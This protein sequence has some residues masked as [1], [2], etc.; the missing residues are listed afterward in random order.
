MS[1]PVQPPLTVETIDGA[2]VGR[3]ITKIKVSN[4]TLT[5]SGS[6]ATITTGGGGGGSGTVTS[7]GL[8]ETGTALTITGSPV[9]T[10]GTI[11][12]AG[13]GTSSQVILGDLS[14]GTLTSGTVTGTGTS[15]QVS[16]WNGTSSQTGSA[17]L[18]FDGTNLKVGGYTE[19]GTKVT[20][21]SGTNL[22]LIPGGAS[23]GSIVI[24]DG[25][26]GQISLNPNGTGT[27]KIDGVEIDNSAIATNYVLKAT[28]TTAA[29]WAAES[30]GGGG[31]GGSISDNQVAV[32]AATADEIEGSTSLTFDGTM[33]KFGSGA[34]TAKLSS[35]GSQDLVLTTN[36]NAGFTEPYIQLN[37]SA[38]GN[39]SI[40]S[41]NSGATKINI[42][43]DTTRWVQ[44]NND[45]YLPQSDGSTDQFLKTNGS[46]TLS[47]S[48]V[49]PTFPLNGPNDS[50]SAPNYSWTNAST[51]G[52]FRLTSNTIGI[53]AGGTAAMYFQSSKVEANKTFEVL[54]GSAASPSLTF[55]G[56]NN[57]GLF[58]AAADAIGFSVGGNER[59]RIQNGAIEGIIFRVDGTDTAAN[60]G[61]A[62]DPDN[63]TGTFSVASNTLSFS[64]GGTER[65]RI[66][67][68]GEI[69]IGGTAA[70]TSGQVLTSG[71]SGAAVTWE[72]AGGGTSGAV[73]AVKP[74]VS[75][76]GS[77]T[78]VSWANTEYPFGNT[79][80]TTQTVNSNQPLYVPFIARRNDTLDEGH[81]YISSAASSA[82]NV[83]IGVYSSVNGAPNTLLGVGTVDVSTTGVKNATLTAELG[84]SLTTVAG[85]QYWIGAVRSAS[86]DFTV[87]ASDISYSGALPWRSTYNGS[88][89]ILSQSGS[90][91]DLPTTASFT[92]GFAYQFISLGVS[93]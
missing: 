59:M 38:S 60:P 79:R 19:V 46:G 49:T 7:V 72:N 1:S 52:L 11:N 91:N 21:P 35:N 70:G 34:A 85:T 29:G 58:S 92:T 57:T 69:L 32:G 44:I 87:G 27:V 2:T 43:R 37:D 14:L 89:G 56:D 22:E 20:T 55:A 12:I 26:D 84:Q 62:F 90:D 66:G 28:S 65:L 3:P 64:T 53:S 40:N 67:S 42:G 82:T 78:D 17:N 23:S 80:T 77:T 4:G 81:I 68:S 75:N 33:L 83:K 36:T 30:G 74:Q 24:A 25:A 76:A 15:G 86:N 51:S 39:I 10:S 16:Y 9:T 18:T 48:D 54:A 6:T 47:F 41:G 50:A 93:Y 88:Y 71:G 31:I 63:D 8:T 5:V 73:D 45:Y 13:A 61:F